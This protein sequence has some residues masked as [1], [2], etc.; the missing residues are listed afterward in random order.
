MNDESRNEEFRGEFR[1][2][3][4]AITYVLTQD[5]HAQA[6]KEDV[7]GWQF[8]VSA[9][10]LGWVLDAFDF[11]LIIFL[12]DTL[13]NNFHVD[14]KE[15]V[16]TIT[17][18][19]AM[20]PVGALLFG[21]LADRYGRKLPLIACVLYFSTITA[22][23]AYAPAFWI[24]VLLRALYGVGMG[25]YWGIG[26]SMAMESA[27]RKWRG[28]LSGLMQSG[29]PMGYLF[30]AVAIEAVLPRVG[31]KPTFLCGFVLALIVTALTIKAPEPAAWVQHR[32]HTF[33]SL[34]RAL[35]EHKGSF[36]YLLVLMMLMNSLSH[37]TQDLYPDFLKSVHHLSQT[38]V[39][40]LAILYN[41]GAITA[42]LIVGHLSERIGRRYS[43][44]IALVVCVIAIPGWAFGA[45]V[46]ALMV[47][48]I[49]MQAGVQGAWGVIPAHLVEL[50]PD[51]VRSL[52]PGL[53]YQLGVLLASP[54]VS[55][56][57]LLRDR[58]GYQGALCAFEGAVILALFFAF[59]FGKERRGKDF[60]A[61]TPI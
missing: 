36:A 12:V 31:W 23:S 20:R 38:T 53:V 24:F 16:F 11:F 43:V 49:V 57:Y 46:T 51:S 10:I 21:S 8:A 37:G 40:H 33:R 18:T 35:L 29:Y 32:A 27:P 41:L 15:I 45:S 58:L 13:A 50:S 34:F 5:A 9:G 30:A 28:V 14:K 60:R 17:L 25:G 54:A 22:C 56:E 48:S 6:V 7:S 42:A 19:L 59:A 1:H 39:A 52:F 47:G 3:H 26:A 4:A 44:M 61:T 2:D 55:V